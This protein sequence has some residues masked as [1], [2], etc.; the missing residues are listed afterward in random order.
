MK[1]KGRRLFLSNLEWFFLSYGYPVVSRGHLHKFCTS[2]PG[3]PILTTLFSIPKT[4]KEGNV[5]TPTSFTFYY[6]SN[7]QQLCLKVFG[8]D[9]NKFGVEILL[10]AVGRKKG[11]NTSLAA[12]PKAPPQPSPLPV[13][14]KPQPKPAPRLLALQ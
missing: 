4:Y 12:K 11:G 14:P 10:L 1:V 3:N 6:D 8:S 7:K 2:T 9:K 5:K 13:L